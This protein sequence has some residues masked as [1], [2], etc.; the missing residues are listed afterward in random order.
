MPYLAM[1]DRLRAFLARGQT[2]LV[3]CGYSFQD[4]H[5]NRAIL[6]GLVG[7]P[8]AVCFGLLYGDRKEAAA[9]I[10]N[11]GPCGNLKLLAADGAVL[12]KIDKDWHS[13]PK[14]DDV[15]PKSA[16]SIGA[17]PKRSLAPAERCKFLLGDFKALG[18]FLADQLADEGQDGGDGDAT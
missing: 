4:F 2:V 1:Q 14:A 12:R 9:A 15:C 6:D 18:H 17:L 7:N 16:V 5:L 3:T 13:A 8:T 11:A 10:M